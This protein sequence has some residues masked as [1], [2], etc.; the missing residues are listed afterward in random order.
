MSDHEPPASLP[1]SSVRLALVMVI[2]TALAL[3]LGSPFLKVPVVLLCGAV[4]AWGLLHMW[5][6]MLVPAERIASQFVRRLPEYVQGAVGFACC[7]A[8][9]HA[10]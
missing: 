2:G 1:P 10:R 3:L 8:L 5:T 6:L 9:L 4:T 7:V